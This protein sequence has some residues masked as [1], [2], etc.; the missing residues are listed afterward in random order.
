[1]AGREYT[2]GERVEI[3]RLRQELETKIAY[4]FPKPPNPAALDEVKKLRESLESF[5]LQVTWSCQFD[6]ETLQVTAEVRLWTL[7]SSGS[8][9]N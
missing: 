3:E 4:H 8:D 1:M 2:E 5:G 6:P 7:K 9:P